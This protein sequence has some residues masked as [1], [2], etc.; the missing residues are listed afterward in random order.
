M[1]QQAYKPLVTLVREGDSLLR[2]R[3]EGAEDGLFVD[4]TTL[5]GYSRLV[6][7][8][9]TYGTG[10]VGTPDLPALT[11][12]VRLPKG[13]NL[14][15][16]DV[17]AVTT[18]WRDALPQGRPLAPVTEGWVKEL[19]APAYRANAKVYRSAEAW[20]GGERVEV[21]NLGV[22]GSQQL[23]RVT[24]RPVAYLPAK[25]TLSVD[26]RIE[27][28]LTVGGK[29]AASATGPERY[30]IVSRPQF[31]DGLQPFVQWKR[32]EGY[33]VT[34]I[35]ANT[36]QR[37]SI[38]A[39]ISGQW[40][41]ASDQW[42]R[43]VLLVGDVVQLQAFRG[44]TRPAGLG[45]HVTDL[46]YAEHTGDYLP[47][48]LLGRWPVSDTAELR[49]VVE[50]TLRYEQCIDFD[51]ARLKRLL[52]V[53]GTDS[54]NPAPV[55]TNGHVN[56]LGYEIK[57][58][59]PEL[60]TFCYRNPESSGRRD[61]ILDDLRQGVAMLSYTAHCGT[62]GWTNP[63]V[64]FASIDT[65]DNPQPLLYVNN[66]CHSNA[67]DG[68]CFGGQLLLK[69]Q[70]GAIGVIG[71][72]N[73]T[74]W[75]EDYYW[76]VGPKYPF[77]VNPEYDATRPGAFDCWLGRVG[78]VQT[79]GELLAAGN[80]AVTAF[81]S[82]YSRFYWEIYCLLGDPS[83]RP[84]VGVPQAA[85]LSADGH[86]NGSTAIDVVG[87]LGATVTAVQDSALLGVATIGTSGHAVLTL[88]RALDTLPLLLTASGYGLVP[89]VDTLAVGTDIAVGVALRDV[90]V[91]DS[92]VCCR[93]ENVGSQRLD[94]LRVVL[95]QTADDSLAGAWI[96]EQVVWVDSLLPQASY[97]VS[98]PVEVT[99]A[100]PRW[101]ATLF[102][103]DDDAGMVSPLPVGHTLP[104][105]LPGIAYRLL[106]T[107]GD[108]AHRLQSRHEYTLE[109]TVDGVA[110]AVDFAVT[111]L[112]TGDT[113]VLSNTDFHL[114]PF[115]F[116]LSTPDTLT[117]LRLESVLTL[118]NQEVRNDYYLVAGDRRDGFEAGFASYPWQQG[119]T[120]PW[121]IDSTVRHSGRFSARSGAI[122]YRQTSDLVLTVLLSQ[123]DTLSYWARTSS[124]AQY[125]KLCFTVDGVQRGYELWGESP[126]ERYT[127]AL[128]AGRHELRWR[129]VKSEAGSEGSDC[130]WIDDVQLPLALWDSAYGWFDTAT[131]GIA[132]AAEQPG[133]TLYPN[134]TTGP[135]TLGSPL[136]IESLRVLDL[137]G[138]TL[139]SA[140]NVAQPTFDF[141]ALPDGIYLLQVV[142][143]ARQHHHTLVIH[144]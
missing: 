20:R 118:G 49:V 142:T 108:E 140:C 66:C 34:E 89:R 41:V 96:A 47:D 135:V 14:T 117:H 102:A 31:R 125:D 71:A 81:G 18:V 76:S 58:A 83:L 70:G 2:V 130:V 19:P 85:T 91:G 52:V 59:H 107:S 43:Y 104:V 35:Y 77:S 8:G 50:K 55:T 132:P 61:A 98:L 99:A 69:P 74:L 100:A 26:S 32:Q 54:R 114:S 1:A 116:H 120:L 84:Y 72:T 28:T 68:T 33:E 103:W 29:A 122:D 9:M 75:N 15:V 48:A 115:T 73:S 46:Y 94:S 144:H 97:T 7:E 80:L 21:E 6:W 112:P 127:V 82:P 39:L 25:G 23:F 141:S 90:A 45:N 37:D 10:R 128:T 121:Q 64:T 11:A 93:V 24:L 126:W 38:K 101:Q 22:M 12:L 16:K 62:A 123:P 42:P 5:P 44:T 86:Y 139:Y 131:V 56:Y 36:D 138:R 110:D 63:S 30:L 65:L 60:D 87:T 105:T 129:Y 95:G 136:P 4:S 113:L 88:G 119:G 78:D 3:F 137:Y 67:F 133:T 51:T 57:L 17:D 13:C 27:A 124:E 40:S 111:A 109:T 79:Q 143:A 53:A 92:V 134:P 106:E